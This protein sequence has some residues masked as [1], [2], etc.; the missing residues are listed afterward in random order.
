M[1]NFLAELNPN[2]PYSLLAFQPQH[3]MRDLPLL[4]WEEAKECLEAAQEEGLE[5]VRLGNT[6]LLK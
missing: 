6:H 3:M 5:R 1:T 4:T 2:I